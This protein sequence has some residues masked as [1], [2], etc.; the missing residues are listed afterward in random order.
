MFLE[1]FKFVSGEVKQAQKEAS[2]FL[3]KLALLVVA[4]LRT[5]EGLTSLQAL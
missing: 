3:L 4:L 5:N 1:W 2:P